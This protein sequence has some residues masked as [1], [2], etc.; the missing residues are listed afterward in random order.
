MPKLDLVPIKIILRRRVNGNA[1]YPEFNKIDPKIRHDMAWSIYIDAYGVGLHYD[2]IENLGTGH[3]FGVACTLVPE[4][5]AIA[6][7]IHPDFKGVVSIISEAEWEEHYNN[8]AHA[9]EPDDI[10]DTEVL[11]GIIARRTLED[12]G[13]LDPPSEELKARRKKALDPKNKKAR[14][15]RMSDRNTWAKFQATIECTIHK[16]HR[17][18][19]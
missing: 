15:I 10:L 9:H 4:D 3:D 11:Q 7:S 12:I 5:F 18:Q 13:E 2:K 1:D 6:A 16:D 14:G 17:K 19:T 8:R